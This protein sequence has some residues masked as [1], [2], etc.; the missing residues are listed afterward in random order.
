[1]QNVLLHPI[2]LISLESG[3]TG[4][5][6]HILYVILYNS[7]N[8]LGSSYERLGTEAYISDSVF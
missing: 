6:L 8:I 1:M 4:G 5:S 7:E 3:T 2:I